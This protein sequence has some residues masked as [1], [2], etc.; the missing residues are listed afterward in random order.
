MKKILSLMLILLLFPIVL[1]V[2]LKVDKFLDK[3]VLILGLDE[4]A[5]FDITVTNNAKTDSFSFYTF[6]ESGIEETEDITIE[7]GE[8]KDITLT[9][10]LRD[11]TKITLGTT[12]FEYFIQGSDRSEITK[13]LSVNVLELGDAFEVGSSSIDPDAQTINVFIKNKVNFNF[14]E[15]NTKFSSPFFN[16]ER[17]LSLEAYGTEEF[18]VNINNE[19]WNKLTAGFYTLKAKVSVGDVN[20]ETE[21][22]IQFLEKEL[23]TPE[24][25]SYGFLIVTKIIKKTNEGNTVYDSETTIEKSIISRPFTTFSKVPDQKERNGGKTAYTWVDKI[26]PGETVEIEIKTNWLLPFLILGFLI[27]SVY[28][29]RKYSSQKVFLRKKVS[30]VKAKG[31]EFALKVTIIAEAREFVEKLKIIDRLPPLVKMYERFGGELPDRISK[32]K[33]RLEWDFNH[34]EVGERRIMSYIVYSKV[35]ILGKFALPGAICRFEQEG[36]SKQSTS[37][38]A[39]FL[40]EQK[41]R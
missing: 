19:D 15:L 27:A 31:G 35:G 10:S 24:I 36:V 13:K 7:S 14:P 16:L 3:E 30:F 11:D 12:N 17:D 1:A 39:Y 18:A 28:F 6:F 33:K 40:S 22:K 34:L 23:I 26:A 37:N 5:T 29:V 2:D 8:T 41:E 4:K 20:G 38:K 25:D 21:G 32:N 9:I